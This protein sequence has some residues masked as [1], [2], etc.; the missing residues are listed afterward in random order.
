MSP[1]NFIPGIDLSHK[2][3]KRGSI[4][5]AKLWLLSFASE[6]RPRNIISSPI[7]CSFHSD[8]RLPSSLFHI[9]S[10]ANCHFTSLNGFTFQRYSYCCQ[11]SLKLENINLIRLILKYALSKSGLIFIIF[12]KISIASFVFPVKCKTSARLF[13]DSVWSG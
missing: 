8:T 3:T 13:K 4:Y 7:P 2:G 5:T 6:I 10:R 9:P 11:P 12:S 1:K